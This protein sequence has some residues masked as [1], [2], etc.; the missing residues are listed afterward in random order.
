MASLENPEPWP[1][2]PGRAVV[3]LNPSREFN[4]YLINRVTYTSDAGL[5][6]PIVSLG[7]SY[8]I[9]AA[10]PT[11]GGGPTFGSQFVVIATEDNTTVTISPSVDLMTGQIAA[12]S[13]Q[14]Q[15]LVNAVGALKPETKPATKT[16]TTTKT[17]AKAKAK[18]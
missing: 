14:M 8:R 10:E 5:A 1:E 16:K 11:L 4:C 13:A 12:L 15:S 3:S 9:M 6:L 18:R 7:N 17:R 2:A